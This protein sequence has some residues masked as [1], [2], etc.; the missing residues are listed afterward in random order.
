MGFLRDFVP[1]GAGSGFAA[2]R[3]AARTA[4]PAGDRERWNDTLW[5]TV[6]GSADAVLRRYYGVRE[7][8]ADPDC[9]LRIAMTEARA[10]LRLADA[11]QIH[12]G[13]AVGVVHLWNEHLPRFSAGGPDLHWANAMRHRIQRSLT[14]LAA[15]VESDAEW[16]DVRAFCA[17][18][19]LS[20]GLRHG[21]VQRFVRRYGFD[22]IETGECSAGS[23]RA[24]GEDIVIWAL[25]RAFN[26]VAVRRQPFLRPRHE[27]WTSRQTLLARYGPDQAATGVASAAHN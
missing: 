11:T 6:V 18:A 21:R 13:E 9:V 4:A 1:D 25:T 10:D 14:A 17:C 2:F 16:R 27:L 20:G 22:L 7:F 5:A 23:L 24:I 19:A 26:P 15:H 3:R 12:Q 8:T